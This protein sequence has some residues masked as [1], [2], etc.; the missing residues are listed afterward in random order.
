MRV[1]GEAKA[2][3]DRRSV[4]KQGSPAA[5]V[6]DELPP[7][8]TTERRRTPDRRTRWRGGRR[9]L[10][11]L[12]RPLHAWPRSTLG[13]RFGDWRTTHGRIFSV[14]CKPGRNVKSRF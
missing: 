12:S 10:D 1:L 2:S 13:S 3:K 14:A 11:W 4:G 7:I 8:V 5:A 6:A 9:D